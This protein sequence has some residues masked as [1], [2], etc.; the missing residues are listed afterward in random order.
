MTRWEQETLSEAVSRNENSYAEYREIDEGW[1]DVAPAHWDTYLIKRR[2]DVQVGK[3]LQTEQKSSAEIELPYLKARHIRERGEIVVNDL[4]TMWFN[5]DDR[6]DYALEKGDVLVAEGGDVGRAAIWSGSNTE[7]L[8]QNA[9]NR[10]RPRSDDSSRFLYYWITWLKKQGY[11]DVLCHKATIA[12]Y[13]AEKVENTPIL[14]PPTEEQRSIADFLDFWTDNLNSLIDS[15]QRLL[16]LLEEK[17]LSFLTQAVT[18]GFDSTTHRQDSGVKSIGPLPEHW[19]CIRLKFLLNQIEQGWSPKCNNRPANEGEWGVL[20]AGAV[21][22]GVFHKSENKALPSDTPRK[23]EFEVQEGD[24]IM[25]R[26]S[27]SPDLIGSIAIIPDVRSKLLL[28]DK[29]YRLHVREEAVKPEYLYIALRSKPLRH[30]IISSI[31]GADGLANNIP[32]S[33]VDELEIPLPPIEEQKSIAEA[34]MRWESNLDSLVDMTR[35]AIN[36]L[37]EKRHALITNGVT[38]QIDVTDWKPDQ[39]EELSV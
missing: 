30:Q 14:L 29:L 6:A 37:Q 7:I 35:E 20:K 21:N 38:G 31:S 18:T 19:E 25:N 2:F 12:H 11:I 33:D 1:L 10:I 22:N 27:G 5:P 23:K 26:A 24:L 16:E 36:L 8:Y 17:R 28:C 4:P 39:K 15:K 3:M 9:I 32:Q 34:V 13:T